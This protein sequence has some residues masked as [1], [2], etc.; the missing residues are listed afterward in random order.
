MT[1][2]FFGDDVAPFG[3][4]KGEILDIFSDTVAQIYYMQ[5]YTSN[6]P[7]AIIQGS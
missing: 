5:I 2:K 3:S 1:H 4:F 6:I 7:C